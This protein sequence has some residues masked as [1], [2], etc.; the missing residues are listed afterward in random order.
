MRFLPVFRQKWQ[1][2]TDGAELTSVLG[3]SQSTVGEKCPGH[4][5]GREKRV[6]QASGESPGPGLHLVGL[7]GCLL[8]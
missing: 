6:R 3:F 1:G 2:K 5:P 4:V 8:A 7:D